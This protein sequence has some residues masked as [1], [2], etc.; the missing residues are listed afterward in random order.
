MKVPV[1]TITASTTS[2]TTAPS[3]TN[4]SNMSSSAD[5]R[6]RKKPSAMSST[7]T[8]PTTAKAPLPPPTTPTYPRMAQRPTVSLS[9]TTISNPT[10]HPNVTTRSPRSTRKPRA[11]TVSSGVSQL[12]IPSRPPSAADLQR[13]SSATGSRV[14]VRSERSD[15]PDSRQSQY[16]SDSR[17]S[18]YGAVSP[19]P[20]FFHAIDA[21]STKPTPKAPPPLR[22]ESSNT[23]KFFFANSIQTSSRSSSP[24]PS[25]RVPGISPMAILGEPPSLSP[26]LPILARS[27]SRGGGSV[28]GARSRPSSMVS[29]G[30]SLFPETRNH[31]KFVY[32]NGTE[33]VLEP[34]GSEMGRG[35]EI[36][37]SELGRSELGRGS[38]EY[39][40]GSELGKSSENGSV[41]H[42]PQIPSSPN[43]TYFPFTKPL[44]P[45]ASPN[46]NIA[47]TSPFQRPSPPNHSRRTSLEGIAA[48][49]GRTLSISSIIDMADLLEEEA[50]KVPE[51]PA[52]KYARRS[53]SPPAVIA[54]APPAMTAKERI[55]AREEAAAKARK[56]RQV[57]DLEISNASLLAIN[58]TLE[59]QLKKQTAEL[60]RYRRLSRSGRIPALPPK[61]K[62]KRR[63][64]NEDPEDSEGYHVKDGSDL[65]AEYEDGEDEEEEEEEEEEEDSDTTGEDGSVGKENCADEKRLKLDLSKHQELLDN[66]AKMNASLKGCQSIVDQLIMEA[67]KALEYKIRASDVHLGGRILS[68]DAEETETELETEA[69]EGT[70]DGHDDDQTE[71]ED[72]EDYD[73]DDLDSEEDEDLEEM[74]EVHLPDANGIGKPI[75]LPT[76]LVQTVDGYV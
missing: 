63:G 56:E 23:G 73:D 2:T 10:L 72:G 7:T 54:L 28:V 70:D 45:T 69:E 19:N 61:K 6:L 50:S 36:G 31:V 76:P 57:L 68:Y 15:R 17:Q 71:T 49:H 4:N 16:R 27:D 51:T 41:L 65:D 67:K 3:S 8:K 37:R 11:D 46:P 44:S 40:R 25:P 20:R 18:Q 30:P 33:E 29:Q 14:S 26:S 43:G 32:A 52:E 13:P 42:S 47:P 58:K 35:S 12:H 62:K 1:M 22:H 5:P 38:S 39:S 48:R 60:R 75:Y 55:A 66:S 9:S 53:S 21:R 34:R 24:A 59:R 64:S 74:E